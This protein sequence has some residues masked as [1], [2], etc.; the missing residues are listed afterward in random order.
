LILTFR[1]TVFFKEYQSARK[2]VDP[3]SR[4]TEPPTP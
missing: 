2:I 4:S 1:D 3:D